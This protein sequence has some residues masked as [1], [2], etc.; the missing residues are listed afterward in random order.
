MIRGKGGGVTSGTTYALSREKMINPE[1]GC[2]VNREGKE[3]MA[4]L[5]SYFSKI[6]T[7]RNQVNPSRKVKTA[8]PGGAIKKRGVGS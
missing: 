1:K 4:T 3:N 6:S 2:G 8:R 5:K 7:V